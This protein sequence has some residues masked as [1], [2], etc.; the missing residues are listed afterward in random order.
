MAQDAGE[1]PNVSAGGLRN[2]SAHKAAG[3]RLNPK[4]PNPKVF[5]EGS[6]TATAEAEAARASRAAENTYVG[7]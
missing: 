7:A 1:P 6:T 4:P 3:W 5:A 2:A